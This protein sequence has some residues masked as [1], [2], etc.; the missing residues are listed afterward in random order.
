M[1][2]QRVQALVQLLLADARS[3]TL[4]PRLVFVIKAQRDRG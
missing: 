2:N 1:T 4:P 3:G